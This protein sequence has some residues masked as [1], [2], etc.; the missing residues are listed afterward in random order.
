MN[1][2]VNGSRGETIEKRIGGIGY[3]LLKVLK[4]KYSAINP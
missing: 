4:T 2:K 1:N 3:R